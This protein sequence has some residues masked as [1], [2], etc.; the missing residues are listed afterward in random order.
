MST[1]LRLK[2]PGQKNQIQIPAGFQGLDFEFGPSH[3][4][5]FSPSALFPGPSI[6]PGMLQPYQR[7][8]EF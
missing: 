1:A 8:T 6:F 7:V 2:N 5:I 4:F 3:L